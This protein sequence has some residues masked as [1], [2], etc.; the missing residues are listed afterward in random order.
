MS[1]DVHGEV[2]IPVYIEDEMK[3]SYL[4]YAMSVIVGRALPNVRDGLKPVHRRI[5]YAMSEMGLDPDKPYRKSARVVGEVLGKYHPHGDA[6]VYESMVRMAQDFSLRYP[7]ID[8]Q[9]NFGSVDGDAPAAMRYTEVRL[10]PISIELLSD[11]K[12]ETVKFA[13]NFD[14]TVEEPTILPCALPNLLVNGSSGIAVGMA[15]NIP[16]H[17]LVEVVDGVLGLIDNPNL[18][19]EDLLDLIPGPDFPTGGIILGRE[20]IKETYLTGKGRIVLRGRADI[21]NQKSGRVTIIIREIPY[22]I[23]KS[24]LLRKI[25]ELVQERKVSG[26][27]H[28][29]DESDRDGMRIVVELKK[30][31][32]P[33]VILNQLYKHTQ[34]QTTF[35]AIMLVL[36]DGVPRTLNLKELLVHYLEHRKEIVRRRTQYQLKVAEERCHILEGLKIAIAHLD[37]IIKLIR[38]SATP[39]EAKKGLVEVFGLSERQAQAILD[40]TLARLTKLE[41]Q[42]VE[43]EYLGL[44]KEIANLKS[45]LASEK[46][47]LSIIKEELLVLKERYGDSRRTQIVEEAGE[48]RVEDMIK[49]EDVVVTISRIGYIKRIPISAYHQQR[50]GGQGVI[51]VEMK[52]E[53]IVEHIFIGS[54]H[55]YILFFTNQGRIHGLKAYQIPEGGRLSRGK[56]LTNFLELGSGETV[57]AV[58]SISSFDV[59]GYLFMAT[60]RGVVKKTHLSAYTNLRSGGIIALSIDPEDELIGVLLTRGKDDVILA[61]KF[62]R[63]LRFSEMR[64]RPM[65]RVARGVKGIRLLK[66][67]EV[68]GMALV[69]EGL[70]LLTV[71]RN[72][73][74]KRTEVTKYPLHN[75]GGQGVIDIKVTQRNGEVVAVLEVDQK[76]EVVMITEAGII[77]R[78]PTKS[79]SLVGRNTQGVRVIKLKQGDQLVGCVPLI[80]EPQEVNTKVNC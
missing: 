72:G 65:G 55:S 30:D 2:I 1:R 12:A 5:L 75:R 66:D 3:S 15:T 63:A 67:D 70:S 59:D 4:D 54:T 14:E 68:V 17:N 53:D 62:G 31:E 20:G 45:I 57:A 46:R 35:A 73:Y 28:L 13:P 41:H 52:E 34:L 76:D 36:V 33:H 8:G 7:L 42:K 39:A 80:G 32:R 23:N 26:I 9:G 64:V 22:Q 56:A 11:L 10:A 18:E 21:E 78:T 48:V 37:E 58:I 19:I 16:P 27:A 47:L 44:I 25:A 77:I 29:R 24:D 69:K 51:G 71:T 50:R 6:A 61:T 60:K 79:I 38:A 74:G 43:E 40:M 49:E